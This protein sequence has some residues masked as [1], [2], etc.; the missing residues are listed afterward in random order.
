MK[1]QAAAQT[2]IQAEQEVPVGDEGEL[3][4]EEIAEQNGEIGI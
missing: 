4:D 1:L 3:T 2:Q